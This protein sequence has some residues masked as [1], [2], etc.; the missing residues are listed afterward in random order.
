MW[1]KMSTRFLVDLRDRDADLL[2]WNGSFELP[3][4]GLLVVGW[5]GLSWS[6]EEEGE[7]EMPEVSE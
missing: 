6:G 1:L 5:S 4:L 7:R 3:V 2:G